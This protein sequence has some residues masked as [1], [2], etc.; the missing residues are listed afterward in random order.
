MK[1]D[2]IRY[3]EI[4]H[5]VQGEG[6]YTGRQTTWIRL[7]KCNLM[8]RGFSQ[9]DPADKTT[10]NLEYDDFA[11]S[12]EM[13]K[14]VQLED[15][16]V[17]KSGCDSYY[18]WHKAYKHLNHVDTVENIVQKIYDCMPNPFSNLNGRSRVEGHFAFTGGEAMLNQNVIV[19]IV[20]EM[21]ARGN[22]PKFIT[23]ETNGTQP[24]TDEFKLFTET[25]LP[26]NGIELCFSIS[27]KLHHVTGEDTEKTIR[28]EVV[29][30]Y[31]KYGDI[32]YLKFVVNEDERTWNDLYNAI[33]AYRN[34]GV[35]MD[36]W[37]MPCGATVEEQE[38]N[39][40]RIATRLVNEGFNV[41]ARVHAYLW[42]NLIGV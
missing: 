13:I 18:S 17:F 22:Y 31:E 25:V 14:L 28:P 24:L 38:E 35:K 29:L 4:F 36:V 2:A 1:T 15:L 27:P 12:D 7:H 42:S 8:C 40:G 32:S 6:V 34:V 5:S 19:A 23:I 26:E 3:S 33:E 30:D 41:S 21:I 11:N 37:G 39:A 10:W 20:N 9:P 16:P